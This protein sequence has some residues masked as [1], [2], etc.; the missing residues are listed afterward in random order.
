MN[1]FTALLAGLISDVTDAEKA[2]WRWASMRPGM[3][4]IPEASMRS[5]SEEKLFP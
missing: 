3:I 2:R 4:V 1:L 5:V